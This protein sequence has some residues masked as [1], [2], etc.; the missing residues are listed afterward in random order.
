MSALRK[1]LSTNHVS[2]EDVDVEKNS[3]KNQ[4]LQTMGIA[5]YP[6]TWVGYT[7][8]K[9]GSDY[10]EIM[11]LLKKPTRLADILATVQ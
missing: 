8:V 7:R 1:E 4:L 5:G 6:A 3:D 11:A 10:S 9:N 2:F